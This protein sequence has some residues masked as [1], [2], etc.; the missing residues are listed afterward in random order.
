VRTDLSA[1]RH[2]A[3]RLLAALALALALVPALVLGGATTARAHTS[4]TATDPAE[5][6]TLTEAP[7]SVQLTFSASVLGGELTVTGPD[8]AAAPVPATVAGP[9]VSAPVALTAPGTYTVAWSVVANDGHPLQGSF[10]FT[11]A[12]PA[13]PTS[14]APSSAAPSSAAPPSAAPSSAATD[15]AAAESPADDGGLTALWAV[16]IPALVVLGAGAVA[17]ALR[18]ARRRS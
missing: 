17:V 2:R 16:G 9:V 18:R 13:A 10:A 5:G 12:P 4:L 6:S 15:E 1:A 3:T 14:A 8:G 7:P 11:F